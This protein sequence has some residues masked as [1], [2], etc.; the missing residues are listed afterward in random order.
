MMG[1]EAGAHL[2][3]AARLPASADTLLR[4]LRRAEHDDGETP[5][6]LGVHD[7]ALRR[8]QRYATILVNLGTREPIDLLP[9]RAAEPFAEWLRQHPGVQLIVRDRSEA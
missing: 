3:H 4:V 9:G 2:A 1:G 7:R 5:R 8:G 6:V